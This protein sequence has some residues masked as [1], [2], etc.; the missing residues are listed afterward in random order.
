[1]ENI[2]FDNSWEEEY[3]KGNALNK[4]PF[5]LV[6]SL[7]FQHFGKIKDKS[8]ISV[9]DVGC[10]AGN[11]SL[12][13][14]QEG[15]DLLGIDGSPTVIEHVKSIFKEKNLKGTFKQMYFD[16]I[17]NINKEFDIVLDRESVYT[18]EL[19]D[20][21]DTFKSISQKLKKDGI[22]I[23][24]FYNKEHPDT[25]YLKETKNN[26][27]YYNPLNNA[28]GNSKRVTLF[29]LDLLNECIKKSNL[30]IIQ[31]YN[32]KIIPIIGA[33]KYDNGISEYIVVA[34]STLNK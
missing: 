33:D 5:D 1:M 7:V 20:V 22:F 34:K 2:N 8:K 30:E 3:Q 27:T 6:V 28:F 11:N 4:Y 23:S 15:F 31:L 10:G 9:L 19:V 21:M 26:Y 29:D 18:L 13:F 24:F 17:K 32:H 16:N 25:R 14:A 12:F